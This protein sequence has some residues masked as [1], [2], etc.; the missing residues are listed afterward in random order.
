M[1]TYLRWL[2]ICLL[3]VCGLA[4]PVLLL[5]QLPVAIQNLNGS[6]QATVNDIVQHGRTNQHVSIDG[7]LLSESGYI[8]GKGEEHPIYYIFLTTEDYLAHPNP[9]YQVLV[10]VEHPPQDLQYEWVN[11]TGVLRRPPTDVRRLLRQDQTNFDAL[12]IQTQ[13]N[14]YLVQGETPT[15]AAVFFGLTGLS[16]A[17]F[18]IGIFL[19]RKKR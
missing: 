8:Y 13:S 6:T 17:G 12:G 9:N 16:I 4:T 5:T 10:E 7:I 2:G 11:I 18:F 15:P 3:I 14:L 1:A 19:L